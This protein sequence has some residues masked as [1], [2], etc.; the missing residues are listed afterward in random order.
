MNLYSVHVVICC[1]PADRNERN[2]KL[3]IYKYLLITVFLPL[4]TPPALASTHWEAS[5]LLTWPKTQTDL[6]LEQ[7][8]WT[9]LLSRLF[10]THR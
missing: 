4:Q 3:Y 8:V 1:S 7:T 2:K 6:H 10:D 5:L 9:F